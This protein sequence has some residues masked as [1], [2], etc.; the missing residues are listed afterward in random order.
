MIPNEELVLSLG[1]RA[2]VQETS[3]CVP[4]LARQIRVFP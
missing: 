1:W 3:V 4:Q 2:P